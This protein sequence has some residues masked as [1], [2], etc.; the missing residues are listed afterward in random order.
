MADEKVVD[1]RTW[2]KNRIDTWIKDA[3]KEAEVMVQKTL[4]KETKENSDE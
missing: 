3:M 2:L 4:G 1:L